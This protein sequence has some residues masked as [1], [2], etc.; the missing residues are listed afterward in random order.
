[1]LASEAI[2]ILTKKSKVIK[3]RPPFVPISE[4]GSFN[5]KDYSKNKI[6]DLIEWDKEF[7]RLWNSIK[8]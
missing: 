5:K 4:Y 3:V 2:N 8:I 1:M 6:N 7:D